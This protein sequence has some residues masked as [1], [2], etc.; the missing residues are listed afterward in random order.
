MDINVNVIAVSLF[1]AG[2]ISAITTTIIFLRAGRPVRTFAIMMGGVTIWALAYSFEL[3]STNIETVLFWVKVEYIGIS[4]IPAFWLIF[5]LQYSGYDSYL[6]RK[7]RAL[8]F[9]VPVATLLIVWTNEWHQLHYTMSSLIETDGLM[10]LN[11]Q[12]GIWYLFFTVTFY[13][14]LVFGTILLVR[15]YFKVNPLYRK[16]IRVILIGT[17]VPWLANMLYLSDIKPLDYLD[18][19]PFTFVVTGI[20][21][22]LGLLRY[23]LFEIVPFAKER[24]VEEMNTGILILDSFFHVIDSNH[25]MRTILNE[26]ETSIL[27][28]SAFTMLRDDPEFIRILEGKKEDSFEYR[29]ISEESVTIYEVFI[30]PLVDHR[31]LIN[32]YF[33]GFR[34][35]TG[36]RMIQDELRNAKDILEEAGELA[37]VGG[38]VLDVQSNRLEM[39]EMTCRIFEFRDENTKALDDAIEKYISKNSRAQLRAAIESAVKTN[40]SYKLELPASTATG[41]KIWIALFG[42]PVMEHGKCVRLVGSVQDITLRKKAEKELL[43]SKRMAESANQAKSEFLANMSHEIRT[44]LNG[45][46]GFSDLLLKTRL[47]EVQKKYMSTVYYSAKSLLDILNDILDLSKIEAG[48]MELYPVVTD[49][50]LLCSKVREILQYQAEQKEIEIRINI[51][52]EVPQKL[53]LDELRIRQILMNLLGNAVKFT[54]KG[55]VELIIGIVNGSDEPRIRFSVKDTGIG[56]SEE[57]QE[58][59]FQ[60]FS[61]V[62]GSVTRE[63]GGTGLGL[64]ISNRILKLMKSTLSLESVPGQGSTFSFEISAVPVTEE[65]ALVETGIDTGDGSPSGNGKTVRRGETGKPG[66]QTESSRPMINPDQK[67]TVLLAED[68]ET[69]RFLLKVILKTLYPNVQCEEAV[70]GEEAVEKFLK[71]LPEMIFMDVQMPIMSGYDATEAIRRSEAGKEVTII[72]CTAGTMKGEREKCL[73]AG[74][75]DYLSKPVTRE[76]V[77]SIVDRWLIGDMDPDEDTTADGTISSELHYNEG[78]LKKRFYG[79]DDIL[80]ALLPAA[81]QSLE[82][83]KRRFRELSDVEDSD[84]NLDEIRKTAHKVKGTALSVSFDRL[85]FLARGL[86]NLDRD[87]PEYVKACLE[88][89]IDEI[90]YLLDNISSL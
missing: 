38:W 71:V 11:F 1:V 20:L 44:P 51:S 77:K 73:E 35:V 45:I 15:K 61:Q 85:T 75:D 40:Q 24:I 55:Y 69:N 34:D 2:V 36:S 80:S 18:L 62:D 83:S 17:F 48:R 3:A 8:I 28:K 25:S 26:T 56:I 66:L 37:K 53:V 64:A 78:Q 39:T 67:F 32:G 6:D 46:I 58:K 47:N 60:A 43:D 74:M 4:L 88:K 21:I 7:I 12:P 84:L 14:Y 57:N 23:K 63:F 42:K 19:T 10:L 22:S 33:L 89:T 27:G 16:Q 87:H 79:S 9:F 68:N 81:K 65:D 31:D 50:H 82:E 30:K 59:I 90:Q 86:E 54:Q 29:K 5:T 72:A 70:N 13:C 76:E 41:K 52:E 49:L